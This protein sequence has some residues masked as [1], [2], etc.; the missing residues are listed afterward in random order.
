MPAQ[1]ADHEARIRLWNDVLSTLKFQL[2]RQEFTT[3]IRPATLH[4]IAG[5]MATIVVP[6]VR[7]KEAIEGNY[8]AL[9]RDLLT[10]HVGEPIMVQV[11]LDGAHDHR[12]ATSLVCNQVG[13]AI[14]AANPPCIP[15]SVP[16]NRPDWIRAERWETLPVMLRAVL[17]GSTVG[18]GQVHAVSPYLDQL[19]QGRYAEIVAALVTE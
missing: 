1:L 11:I 10:M 7:V 15:D 18:D 4:A 16:N 19:L 9:L 5:G 8:R 2:T 13:T 3:W 17:I 6:N 12:P 14:G